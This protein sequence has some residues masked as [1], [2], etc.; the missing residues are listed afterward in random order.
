MFIANIKSIPLLALMG[1]LCACAGNRKPDYKGLNATEALATIKVPDGFEVELLAAEPLVFSPVDMEI[2]EFGNLY[3]VEMPGYPLDKTL[4]GKIV[5]ISDGDGDGVMDKRTIFRDGLM[6]PT[7]IQRWKNGFLVTDAPHIFYLEDKDKDGWA[8]TID[9]LITGFGLTNPQ[10]N[11]N[12]P[13]YGLDNWIYV[14]H[15]NVIKTRDYVEEFG[16]QGTEVYYSSDPNGVRLPKNANGRSVRFKPGSRELEMMSNQC[17]FGQTFDKWGR[18]LGSSNSNHIFQEMLANRYFERN[19]SLPSSEAMTSLSD[20]LNAA[21]V[22][23]TTTNP[24]RQL[25]TN[26]GVMTSACGITAYT[27]SA[28]PAPFDG[29]IVFVAEPVSNLVHVDVLKNS[30][31][32]YSA[33]RV[34]HNSE[35]FTS[36]DYWSRPVNM[37]VGPDGALYILDY[38]RRVIE[39][40]EWMSKEAIEEGNLYD[41]ID[42][43]RIYRVSAKN[44]EKANWIKQL[45]F[46]RASG[47]ELVQKLA[48]P[49]A[50][51]RI[52]AQRLLIDRK[53][54]GLVS[55]LTTMA[56]T[57]SYD[58]ARLHALWTLE[59][60]QQLS[61]ETIIRALHD[62]VAGIRE[63]AIR[64]AE[65]RL[66]SS[67]VL[68]QELLNMGAEKDPKARFQLLLTL[69]QLNSSKAYAVRSSILFNN[70]QDKWI[71]VAALSAASSHTGPLLSDVLKRFNKEIP[72]YAS[73]IERLTTMVGSTDEGVLV[74]QLIQ[75]ATA[76][77]HSTPKGWEASI[78]TG[79][80]TGIQNRVSSQPVVK[81]DQQKLVELFFQTTSDEMRS[82][83]LKLLKVTGVADPLLREN[84]VARAIAQATDTAISVKKRAAAADLI[85]IG[86]AD[87]H[88]SVLTGLLVP[89]EPIPVQLAALRTMASISGTSGCEYLIAEWAILTAEVR[90]SSIPLFL[91]DSTKIRLLIAAL[92]KG[93]ISAG[94][95]GFGA[96]V[97]LML[98]PIEEIRERAR[99]L[100]TDN[101]AKAKEVANSYKEALKQPGDA[102]K[103]K[104]VYIDNCAIC[105]QIKG[106]FGVAFGPDLG[107]IHNWKKDDVLA[108]IIDPNLAIVAGFDIWE[109]ETNDREIV[110]GVVAAESAT[111]VT[112]K[113]NGKLDV[114]INRNTIKSMKSLGIS[115]MPSGL[116][117]NISKVEMANLLEFLRK[118]Q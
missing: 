70:I 65:S 28:F 88:L 110:Q 109:V 27:G 107:T 80:A 7:G 1:L 81:A 48:H 17:Q 9:T 114:I 46:G 112:L 15:E 21:E 10:H 55:D 77:S 113:N 101:A 44:G 61:Q 32:G 33:S 6:L 90:E 26:V 39:S 24:D 30:D 108:N 38:Y 93:V 60:L 59:G 69:G 95:I 89:R 8:E 52:N 34:M 115:A 37:Y 83:A 84:T 87:E 71:Q 3:V 82:A 42:K 40:P 31:A 99:K 5:H 79:L 102:E 23:P 18:W 67:P 2:D 41:G 16:D 19:M 43:G 117:K 14:A 62:S 97:S 106:S 98:N 103:G 53:E 25:L 51:W 68:A 12:S 105:H 118:P 76:S 63:N 100:F 45:E 104:S 85:S 11:M 54:T 92:E 78:L 49:N 94:T 74:S 36:T 111:A 29:D 57:N 13:T 116:E 66:S 35:F 72:A 64:L 73:L 4:S 75:Q 86:K 96:S 20:H 58:M 91:R 56:T 50:W 22:F 47:N